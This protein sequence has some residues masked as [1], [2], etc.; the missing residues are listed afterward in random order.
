[1]MALCKIGPVAPK[2]A[3]DFASAFCL[4]VIPQPVGGTPFLLSSRDLTDE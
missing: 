3:S 1:M 4:P 2:G